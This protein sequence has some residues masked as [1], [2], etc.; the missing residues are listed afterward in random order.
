MPA[1]ISRLFS[2][3]MSRP[4]AWAFQL[5]RAPSASEAAASAPARTSA[6]TRCSSRLSSLFSSRVRLLPIARPW[7]QYACAYTSDLGKPNSSR[8]LSLS[9]LRDADSHATHAFQSDQSR[10]SIPAASEPAPSRGTQYAVRRGCSGSGMRRS[11]SSCSSR[12][13]S[14]GTSAG[15]ASMMPVIAGMDAESPTSRYPAGGSSGSS[16]LVVPSAMT[17]TVAPGSAARAQAEAGPAGSC[18]TTSTANAPVA[19]SASE[20]V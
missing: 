1:A 17:G 5:P 6:A 12:Y 3:A 7:I 4:P 8:S 9:A 18:R 16:N 11:A 19:G 2:G 10:A 20:S 14:I 13:S 15:T